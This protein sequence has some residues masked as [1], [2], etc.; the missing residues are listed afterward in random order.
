MLL[1][2]A[3][4]L[5]ATVV[6]AAPI[7]TG[8]GPHGAV[9]GTVT[10]TDASGKTFDAPGVRLT[11]TCAATPDAVQ[12]STSD[13]H[14]AFRFR[15]VLPD[16]CSI[17]AELQGFASATALAVVRVGDTVHAA[18]HLDIAPVDT[19]VRVVGESARSWRTRQFN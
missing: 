15:D 6:A 16:R 12:V 19:G 3:A 2:F 1:F 9:A 5:T 7:G 4:L 10:L 13:D 18:I 14:G 11:L 8:A 17:D